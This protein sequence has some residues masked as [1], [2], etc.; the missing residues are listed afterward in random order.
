[1]MKNN[2]DKSGRF[3]DVI[4]TKRVFIEDNQ[5]FM[6]LETEEK[7]LVDVPEWFPTDFNRKQQ[8]E[9]IV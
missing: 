5:V 6:R 2:T 1:M 4:Q 8:K 3:H 9:T 7:F